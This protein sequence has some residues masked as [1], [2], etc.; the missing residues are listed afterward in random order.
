MN[1]RPLVVRF[2]ALG[3]M[4]ILTVI[5]RHLY[6]RFAE[7]VDILASGNW[8]RPLLEG[9]PGVGDIYVISSRKRPYWINFA[10]QRLVQ[11]LRERGASATWLCDHDNAKTMRV[12]ERAG[13][14]SQH[15]CHYTHLHD[16]PGPH[17]CDL[18]LRYAY[19]NPP[20]LGGNDLPLTAHDAYGQL[21]ATGKQRE[22]LHAWL[23]TRG[24]V[25]RS[26]ILV[27][28]GN[29][30]TMRRGLRQRSSNSKYW[31]EEQWSA[32]LRGLR[33]LHPQH[34]ILLLGVPQEAALNDE[35]LQLAKLDNAY[36]IANEL[37]L[38]RLLALCERATGMISVDTGPAHV[39]AAASCPVLT[40]FGRADPNAY[41]PRGPSG[42]VRWLTGIHEGEASMLGIRPEQVLS[43][44][45]ALVGVVGARQA[46]P[47]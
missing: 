42:Q 35:I 20:I 11:S 14:N 30:R 19:R 26:L 3:D 17:F 32:V 18:Y 12:L 16:V 34:T 37:P 39:A 21:T 28:V 8:T 40:L 4:V 47:F 1:N 5:I 24:L 29:K 45:Q 10:Q 22:A 2:G 13:W 27:Q 9:Q 46:S 25:D 41:A 38:P 6:A 31:P 43:E 33:E 44:W 7:P 15:W 36:N 23:Q